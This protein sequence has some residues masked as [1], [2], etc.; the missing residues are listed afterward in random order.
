MFLLMKRF[1]SEK[2]M[3][4]IIN[5][6]IIYLN[7]MIW[8]LTEKSVSN[9]ATILNFW[10]WSQLESCLKISWRRYFT[11]FVQREW[12]CWTGWTISTNLETV[13]RCVWGECLLDDLI[14]KIFNLFNPLPFHSRIFPSLDIYILLKYNWKLDIFT[15]QLNFL[16]N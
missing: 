4:L 10:Q 11:F 3:D 13:L 15:S 1:V 6:V 5:K 8:F 9:V 14:I 16:S 7:V 2:S 12:W